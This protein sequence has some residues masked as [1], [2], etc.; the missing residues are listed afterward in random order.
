[1]ERFEAELLEAARGGACVEVPPEVVAALGGGG[2]I[3]VRATFD[4]IDYRGSIVSMGGAKVLGVLKAIREELGKVPGDPLVVT[5]TRDEAER[6]VEVPG[7]LAAA[8]DV[9][10][11]RPA[12]DALSFSHQREHV[13]WIEEA[14]KPETR[15]RR[16]ARTVERLVADASS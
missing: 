4:G 12:F 1:M 7:E 9:A 11:A 6:R 2:R 3:P 13:R 8:L 14:K 10:G 15:A 16:V 5:V